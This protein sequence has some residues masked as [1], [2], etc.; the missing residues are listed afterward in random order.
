[1]IQPGLES[2]LAD[3]L[4]RLG[5]EGRPIH[6]GVEFDLRGGAL[7]DLHLQARTAT[8]VWVRLGRYRATTLEA[9]AQGLRRLPWVDYVWPGQPL[10]LRV[11][12]RGSR[13]RYRDRIARKAEYAVRD[14]LRAARRPRTRR[15]DRDPAQRVLVRI[16][17][18]DVEVSVDA[19][20]EPL[21]RRGWRTDVGEA[22]LRETLA[23]AV[24]MGVGWSAEEPLVDPMCG[25]GTFCV[26]AAAMA[27]GEAPGA[28]RRF[29]FEGWPSHDAEAWAAAKRKAR[30][31]GSSAGTGAPILGADRDA[32]VLDAARANAARARVGDR[33]ELRQSDAARLAPP[34]A[35]PGLVVCNPP[36]GTRLADAE[37]A[38]GALGKGLRAHFGGWRVALLV[39]RRQLLRHLGQRLTEVAQFPSGGIRISLCT[40]EV[41]P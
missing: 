11:T 10:D 34:C 9:L 35:G 7:Y 19:S 29:A 16:V 22:P 4:M 41:S 28:S 3:E 8:R 25:S 26:E 1:M 15:G 14:A 31:S 5:I 12:S 13:L 2:V 23:A 27:K 37:R 36:W 24:L 20:G 17:D 39:P 6:G 32:R 40:G 18:D 33:V 38:W 30:R 21:Y